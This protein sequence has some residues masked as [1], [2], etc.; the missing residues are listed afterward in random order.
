MPVIIRELELRE[1]EWSRI[2]GAMLTEIEAQQLERTRLIEVQYPNFKNGYTYSIRSLRSVGIIPIHRG[3]LVRILPKV[4][5]ANLFALVEVAYRLPSLQFY[6]GRASTETVDGASLLFADLLARGVLSRCRKGLFAD[7]IESEERGEYLRGSMNLAQ[8]LRRQ[9]SGSADI[10]YVHASPTI[11]I[12]HNQILRAALERIPRLRLRGEIPES[13]RLARRALAHSVSLLELT[14]ADVAKVVYSR[15]NA[16]YRDLHA[17]AK[18][19]LE[20]L[21]PGLGH[22]HHESLPFKIDMPA[23]FER[24]LANAL[25]QVL[26]GALLVMPKVS[27][28]VAGAEGL[29]L[30][31]DIVLRNPRSGQAIAVLD[32]KYKRDLHPSNE[33]FSQVVTYATAMGVRRAFLVYPGT[34]R[35][36]RHYRVGET[37]V[38]ADYIDLGG[39]VATEIDRLALRLRAMLGE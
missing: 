37:E 17:L 27:Y 29:R 32:A 1:A 21:A 33:D 34:A 3:L 5:V 39:A 9:A 28:Q 16:D 14:G 18:M 36:S 30:E 23:L 13:V 4:P 26:H 22:G 35:T 10:A 12:L 25:G 20:A 11:D 19:F 31:M 6:E 8:T 38:T 2:E 15:L 7:Y 24:F